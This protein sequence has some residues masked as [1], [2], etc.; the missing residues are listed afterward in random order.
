M[1]NIFLSITI[2]M[3]TSSCATSTVSVDSASLRLYDEYR[4]CLNAPKNVTKKSTCIENFQ[5]PQKFY[6]SLEKVDFDPEDLKILIVSVFVSEAQH[7]SFLPQSGIPHDRRLYCKLEK[8]SETAKKLSLVDIGD[9]LSVLGIPK[10]SETELYVTHF[11]SG[12]HLDDC[13]FYKLVAN[14]ES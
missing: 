4:R 6:G 5:A 2:I 8:D 9:T 7:S 14:A 1:K 12:V 10:K 13:V 11:E 3:I